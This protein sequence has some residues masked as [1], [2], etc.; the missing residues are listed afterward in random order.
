M[1]G[2]LCIAPKSGVIGAEVG[3]FDLTATPPADRIAE[4]R[5]ALNRLQ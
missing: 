3:G 2:E 4:L 5:Q 1:T